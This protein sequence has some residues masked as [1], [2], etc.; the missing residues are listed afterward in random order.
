MVSETDL[1][2]AI[3]ITSLIALAI[4]SMWVMAYFFSPKG[5]IWW[6]KK[7]YSGGVIEAFYDWLDHNR[8]L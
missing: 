1:Q 8:M 4:A 6:I 2:V 5:R 7:R 3:L